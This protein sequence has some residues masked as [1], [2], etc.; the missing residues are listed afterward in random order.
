MSKPVKMLVASLTLSAG[1]FIGLVE[2]ENYVGE[3]MIPTKNDR[4]T[5]GFGS[6]FHENGAP[7]KMGDKVTPVKALIKAKAHIDREEEIFRRSLDGASLSQPEFDVYMD[8]V[9]QYGT[10]TWNSSSMRRDILAGKHAQACE[11]LLKYHFSGGH[12]CSVPGNRI[13]SGVWTRQLDRHQKCM[14]ANQ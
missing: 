11:D 2:H 12:D 4:P 7:V 1:A 13:C 8:F 10:G 6:T 5:V 9:Y 3:A 14:G